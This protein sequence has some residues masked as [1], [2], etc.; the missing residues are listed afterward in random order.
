MYL[1]SFK[2]LKYKHFVPIFL[3]NYRWNLLFSQDLMR[4]FFASWN[5]SL[6]HHTSHLSQ[7]SD[8]HELSST[9]ILPWNCP[10]LWF[11]FSFSRVNFPRYVKVIF[12]II[13]VLF[14]LS[15]YLANVQNCLYVQIFSRDV[16]RSEN[17]RGALCGLL[18]I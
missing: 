7:D 15:N 5:H 12:P 11:F 2:F 13:N 17:L 16:A 9:Y 14:S 3:D 18:R 6:K 8:V 10:K 1:P 4:L